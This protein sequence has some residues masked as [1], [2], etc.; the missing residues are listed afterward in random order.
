[1]A[2]KKLPDSDGDYGAWIREPGKPWELV[3]VGDEIDLWE[4][5]QYY[6]GSDRCSKIVLPLGETPVRKLS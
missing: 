5:L 2:R 1:M 4:S 6:L 3:A